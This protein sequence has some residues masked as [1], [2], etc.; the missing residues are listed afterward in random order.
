MRLLSETSAAN[1]SRL[2]E[3]TEVVYIVVN[4]LKIRQNVICSAQDTNLYTLVK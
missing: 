3:P 1:I 4:H 2:R